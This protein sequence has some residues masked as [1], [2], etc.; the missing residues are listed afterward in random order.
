MKIHEMNNTLITEV[1]KLGNINFLTSEVAGILD[2]EYFNVHSYSKCALPFVDALKESQPDNYIQQIAV[3][4]MLENFTNIQMIYSL[5]C[6][7][8]NIVV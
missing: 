8:I 5:N 3:L 7:L 6:G 2:F 4:I 1:S